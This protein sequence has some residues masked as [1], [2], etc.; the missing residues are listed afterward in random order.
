M[1]TQAVAEFSVCPNKDYRTL[2]TQDLTRDIVNYYDTC[3]WD[4]RFAWA[5]GKNLALHYGY[6]DSETK[7]HHQSL[8][9]MNKVLA[10]QIQIN[11]SDY[12]LDAGCGLGGS[13]IW[14]AETYGAK[15][16]GITLSEQQV[17]HATR[18]AKQRGVSDIVTFKAADFCQ[19]PFENESFDVVWGLESACY[20]L[21][22]EDFVNEAHR[23]LRKGGRLVV[24]DGFAKRTHFTPKEWD[25]VVTCLNGWSVPNLVTPDAFQSYVEKSGFQNIEYRDISENT[26]RSAKRMYLIALINYPLQKLFRWLHIR[27]EVQHANFLTGLYQYYIIRGG[28]SGYGIISGVKNT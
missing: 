18:S 23:V 7:S 26:F 6:W 19:T 5:N 13:A 8:F 15:V 4:Y 24:A 3:Y 28:M 9:N 20:A 17:Q 2:S 25:M 11:A 27:S 21:N 1:N 10:E 16:L 12:I 14:L 22:K